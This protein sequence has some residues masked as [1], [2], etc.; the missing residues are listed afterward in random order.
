MIA[1]RQVRV[2]AID[3]CCDDSAGEDADFAFD[4]FA[5]PPQAGMWCT[6]LDLNQPD[7]LVIVDQLVIA[8]L[9]QIL[10]CWVNIWH[11]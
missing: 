3:E 6:C 2:A 5:L 7:T 1:M 11:I 9:G 8:F 4:F 10:W